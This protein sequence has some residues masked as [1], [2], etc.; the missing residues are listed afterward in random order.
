MVGGCIQ[1]GGGGGGGGELC[2]LTQVGVAS[3]PPMR[4][5]QSGIQ[6]AGEL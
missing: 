3:P 6:N 2:L 5:V 4:G 1:G